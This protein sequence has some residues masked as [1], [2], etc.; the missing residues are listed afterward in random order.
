MQSSE[1][2]AGAYFELYQDGEHAGQ[3]LHFI[4]VDPV[5]NQYY[6][7][8]PAVLTNSRRPVSKSATGQNRRF[9]ERY[10]NGRILIR[11]QPL[12][13]VSANDHFWPIPAVW[14]SE[15]LRSGLGQQRRNS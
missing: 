3:R 2:A 15:R 1:R 6:Q 8:P 13:M 12:R 5:A 4:S 7:L 9:E 11:K 14:Q 10:P